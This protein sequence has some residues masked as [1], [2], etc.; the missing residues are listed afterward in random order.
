MLETRGTGEHN[1][2]VD[3]DTGTIKRTLHSQEHLQIQLHV[4]TM[5]NSS[6]LLTHFQL[7]VYA[8]L[9]VRVRVR[10]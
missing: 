5:D 3:M 1:N 10:V 8:C 6:S 7:S 4:H 9:C 2:S